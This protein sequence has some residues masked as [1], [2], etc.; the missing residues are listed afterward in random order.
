MLFPHLAGVVVERVEQIG[1]TVWMW[2]HPRAV[3]AACPGC[4]QRSV[5]V[6]SRYERRVADAAV[7]GRRL[8]IRLRVRRFFCAETACPAKTFAEQVTG[9]TQP[10]RR[11]TPL[12]RTMLEAIGLAVAGRAGAR[13][14]AML[15]L[16]AS[17]STL[18]R[19]IRA[20][21]DPQAGS[22]TVL[23]VDDFALRRGHN[24]GT[25]LI[26]MDTHRPVDVLPD[27]EAA[28]LATWLSDHPGTTVVCRDRAGAYAEGARTGA[29]KAIQVADRWHL[30]HNLAGYTEKTIAAHHH[31]VRAEWDPQPEA[32]PES[33]LVV[34]VRT[35]GLADT[36]QAA[37]ADR[38]E[39]SA[40]IVRTKQR[41]EAV[42]AMKATGKGI[43]AIM[44]ELELAK[45]T[46]RRFYR[47]E[48]VDELL[49]KARAGRPV[50]LDEYKPYLH[51][52]WNEG[53]TNVLQLHREITTQGY[54]G[55][56]SSVRDHLA[57]FRELSAAPPAKPTTPKV[58]TITSWMLRRP[59]DLDD[60]DRRDLTRVLD[61][62]SHLSATA[63]HVRTFAQMLTG[64]H[65][66][67]L[68]TWMR[69]VEGDD[70]P[71]LR[72]FVNGLR[73]DYAAVLNGLTLHHSSGAVEGN[74]NRI[75][76]IKRQMYGRA[77]FDLLRKRILLAD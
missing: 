71:Y 18:L 6:H 21:P 26:D 20:L 7:A 8:V 77:S 23:G 38:T 43:K 10:Y 61:V 29:P 33:Q 73:Q 55:C 52:R 50:K 2:A 69:D 11:R 46:V 24:Y 39:Q 14:A 25:V 17:R 56:Y 31:C 60:H 68:D 12:L 63:A 41:Y 3:E 45:D 74:V 15:G 40:L 13:L 64:R 4:G 5:R 51:R 75:K 70:L 49:A 1:S 47:A 57:P 19:L 35:A 54:R 72:S 58:R 62:C 67:R 53:C 59:E 42:Q 48:S 65:G 66:E 34:E 27:R 36:A 9:L 28:T 22:V 37:L 76:M 32:Q 16:F 30:W 44:R